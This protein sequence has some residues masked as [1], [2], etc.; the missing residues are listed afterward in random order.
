[1]KPANVKEYLSDFV[2]ECKK[3]IKTGIVI[4]EN[5]YF[6]KIIAVVA[7]SQA[8]SFI[9]LCKTAGTFYA[10]ERCTKKGISVGEKRKKR[11]Y[12]EMNC[13]LR[14]KES[15]NNQTQKGHHKDE[16]K[17]LLSKSPNVDPVNSVIL[18][19]MHI[20]YLGVMKTLME[21]WIL[22]TSVARLRINKV[23]ELK[24]KFLKLRSSVPFEFQR[25]KFYTNELARWKATQFHFVLLYCGPILKKKVLPHQFYNH[26]VL[27]FVASRILHFNELMITFNNYAKEL[28][29][30]FFFYC[31]H[32]TANNHKHQICIT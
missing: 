17:S 9:K 20:L 30:K 6:L 32:Y 26:F 24:L 10:C 28:L 5:N 31:H 4:D 23:I 1:M 2:K 11:V 3:L 21:S 18:D 22:R 15:F 25:K 29:R 27:L 16:L 8:R 12:P 7:D 19:S 13:E 14:T